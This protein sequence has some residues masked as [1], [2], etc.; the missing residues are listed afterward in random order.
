MEHLHEFVSAIILQSSSSSSPRDKLIPL[1]VCDILQ[2]C[3][4]T[5][6]TTTIIKTPSSSPLVQALRRLE[7]V[8]ITD[9]G[10]KEDDKCASVF[11]VA[12][13]SGHVDA[14]NQLIKCNTN[15]SILTSADLPCVLTGN[16]P[17]LIVACTFGHGD[18]VQAILSNDA[19]TIKQVDKHG[20][21]PLHI[22]A[23]RGHVCLI[24]ILLKHDATLV[25]VLD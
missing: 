8:V 25:N 12:I 24:G 3:T 11:V 6:T 18:V 17:A 1:T 5:T 10:H 16:N 22:A 7:P 21:T 23:I 15:R 2:W 13:E 4:P 14:V 9:E 19:S 20:R